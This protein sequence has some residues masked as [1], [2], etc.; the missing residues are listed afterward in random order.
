MTQSRVGCEDVNFSSIS[1]LSF[2]VFPSP[3]YGFSTD[4]ILYSQHH[5]SLLSPLIT[6]HLFLFMSLIFMPHSDT[7]QTTRDLAF[8]LFI[9]K[10]SFTFH[11]TFAS[12]SCHLDKWLLMAVAACDYCKYYVK[13]P[14]SPR[15]APP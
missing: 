1:S 11:L 2:T 6:L 3:G 14:C 10:I 4:Y 15:P 8:G 9:G 7:Q 5:D 13:L 12:Q